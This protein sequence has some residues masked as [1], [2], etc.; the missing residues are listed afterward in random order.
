MYFKLEE[1]NNKK[2]LIDRLFVSTRDKNHSG[3]PNLNICRQA[4]DWRGYSCMKGFVERP[5]NGS[6]YSLI[7][8]GLQSL[9]LLY[10]TVI[11]RTGTGWMLWTKPFLRDRLMFFFLLSFIFC[12]FLSLFFRPSPWYTHVVGR[13]ALCGSG[14]GVWLWTEWL[15]RIW[16]NQTMWHAHTHTKDHATCIQIQHP[17]YFKRSLTIS[18]CYGPKGGLN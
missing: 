17:L 12:C 13:S 11:E 6:T 4:E 16:L 9:T 5:G 14:A 8:K 3:D 10:H 2:V 7:P 18:R 15:A 1:C